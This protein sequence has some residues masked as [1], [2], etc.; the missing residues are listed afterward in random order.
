MCHLRR[1]LRDVRS[2]VSVCLLVFLYVSICC[3]TPSWEYCKVSKGNSR[4][5]VTPSFERSEEHAH[6]GSSFPPT[7]VYCISLG[8]Q[9]IYY[10][11]CTG[12]SRD[13]SFVDP[14][15]RL[16]DGTSRMLSW[17]SCHGVLFKFGNCP[18]NRQPKPNSM[19]VAACS[20][21][22]MSTA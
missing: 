21:I 18:K 5:K 12:T 9:Y 4:K 17:H 7:K 20:P 13:S 1:A 19:L 22:F 11:D 2:T 16:E 15:P 10:N 6:I 14:S 8:S 3:P